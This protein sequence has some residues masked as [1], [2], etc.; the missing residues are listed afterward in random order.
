[1]STLLSAYKITKSFG[2]L[3]ANDNVSFKI[4]EGEILG[5]IGPNGSGKT[6]LVNVLTGFYRPDS[7]KLE[8]FGKVYNSLQAHKIARL[9]I[10]RTFQNIRLFNQMSVIENIMNGY[11]MHADKA[12]ILQ[13]L[14][15]LPAAHKEEK[16]IYDFAIKCIEKVGLNKL[17]I[18]NK[19][20][21]LSYG[22]QRLTE[23]ARALAT[24]PKLLILDEPAAGM[25]ITEIVELRECLRSLSDEGIGILIID[26]R[27]DIIMPLVDKVMVM[28]FGQKIA[29]GNP[30]EIQNN[31]FVLNAYLGLRN[32]K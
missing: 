11:Y 16:E 13:V 1:M 8:F 29:E 18:D 21:N 5:L 10:S 22:E 24:K 27:M 3:K 9:G 7:G 6:T 25:N 14:F 26:H 30:I 19:A 4:A 31:E 15:G 20:G 17:I 28:N 12:N 32:K 23:I 2:G